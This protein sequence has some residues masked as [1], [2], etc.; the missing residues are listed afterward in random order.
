MNTEK[1]SNRQ[2]LSIFI[3]FTLGST[4]IL[5]PWKEAGRDGW[6]SILIGMLMIVPMCFVY[7]RLVSLFPGKDLF[8]LQQELFGRIIGKITSF[9]LVYYSIHLCI[10]VNRD[11]S[12]FIQTMSFPE[13]PLFVIALVGT[14]LYIWIVKGGIE[15]IGRYAAFML[16]IALLSIIIVSLLLIPKL[17]IDNLRPVM[18]NGMTPVLK[19]AALVFGFPFAE[20]FLFTM[21]FDSLRNKNKTLK[22][23]LLGIFLSGLIFINTS[24]RNIA[25]LGEKL[26]SMLY[27]PSYLAVGL[28][29]IK[30]FIDRIEVLVGADFIFMGFLKCSICLYTA[31]KG[32]SKIF[33]I[34]DY[35]QTATPIGFLVSVTTIFI[36][37]SNME[38]FEWAKENYIYYVIPF[39]IILPLITLVAAEFRLRSKRHKSSSD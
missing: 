7:S 19:G 13:T 34:K 24:T 1:I 5:S 23:Y 21:V 2:G 29:N 22:I 16:P 27:F 18:Y 15:V 31:C 17:D 20:T 25:V 38:M 10:L 30:D 8:D 26:N 4:L 3:M 9:F 35:R 39:S 33:N 28:V 37:R 32:F 14:V 11:M 12:G 36:Y 6:I